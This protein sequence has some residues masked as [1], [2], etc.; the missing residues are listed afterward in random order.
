MVSSSSKAE[1]RAAAVPRLGQSYSMSLSVIWP[2]RCGMGP[3]RAGAYDPAVE[4]TVMKL[5][6][7]AK[8]CANPL[9][10]PAVVGVTAHRRWRYTAP[11]LRA[12]ICPIGFR[13]SDIGGTLGMV[14]VCGVVCVWCVACR[15]GDGPCLL[16]QQQTG[17]TSSID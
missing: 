6:N 11:H 3:L 14:C 16:H 17:V 9:A 10:V 12:L 5:I 1:A 2:N 7:V 13:R 8:V 4:Q 15:D